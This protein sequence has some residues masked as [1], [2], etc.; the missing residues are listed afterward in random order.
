MDEKILRLEAM[1]KQLKV[2]M[3]QHKMLSD[4]LY[5]MVNRGADNQLISRIKAEMNETLD[6]V[7]KIKEDIEHLNGKKEK[8]TNIYDSIQK[9][10]KSVNETLDSVKKTAEEKTNLYD[11]IGKDFAVYDTPYNKPIN[12]DVP[13]LQDFDLRA[14][15]GLPFSNRFIVDL[16]DLG[17]DSWM[18]KSVNYA[19]SSEGHKLYL[20][21]YNHI[22]GIGPGKYPLYELIE[23]SHGDEFTMKVTYVDPTGVPIYSEEYVDCKIIEYCKSPLVY[24]VSE[25]T[26]IELTIAYSYVKYDTNVRVIDAIPRKKRVNKRRQ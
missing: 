22:L 11:A 25:P 7:N 6:N 2:M 5:E 3:N 9:T 19:P 21:L 12:E 4:T 14:Y 13:H 10:M 18:V 8:V 17:I 15:D 23:N 20:N 16:D 26:N 24:N 1:E